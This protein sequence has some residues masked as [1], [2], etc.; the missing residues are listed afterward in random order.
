LTE[1]LEAL[2]ELYLH[3]LVMLHFFAIAF[4]NFINEFIHTA[5]L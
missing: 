5:S 3:S 1:V 2:C 4:E